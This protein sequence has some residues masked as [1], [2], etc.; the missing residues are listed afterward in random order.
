MP[1]TPSKN[2][3]C[4]TSKVLSKHILE[5]NVLLIHHG[6][7]SMLIHYFNWQI[8]ICLYFQTPMISPCPFVLA[9]LNRVDTSNRHIRVRCVLSLS[10][11]SAQ[12]QNLSHLFLIEVLI[13]VLFLCGVCFWRCSKRKGHECSP[14]ADFLSHQQSTHHFFLVL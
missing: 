13:W 8:K 10:F 4:C 11:I 2:A 14:P 5:W 7:F 1:T 12:I 3:Y 6:E 9:L